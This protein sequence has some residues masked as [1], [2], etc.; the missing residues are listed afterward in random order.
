VTK[1]QQEKE[2]ETTHAEQRKA[3]AA[4]DLDSAKLEKE[5]Q[6]ALGEG[7]SQRKKLVMMADGALEKKLEA[8]IKVNELYA[9]AIAEYKGNWVPTISQG[10]SS[11]SGNGNGATALI[12]LLSA[13]AAK[14]LALDLSLPHQSSSSQTDPNKK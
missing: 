4:L 9:K 1:A 3:V 8:Y 10:S 2:V 6:I 13:K 7:E 14:D 5:K 11:I 12:D